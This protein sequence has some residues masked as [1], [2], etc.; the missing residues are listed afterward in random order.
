[1][2]RK[3]AVISTK[4]ETRSCPRRRPANRS[5]GLALGRTGATGLSTLSAAAA[6]GV[7]II[8]FCT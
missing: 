4:A 5:H 6:W 7:S 3:L 2:I 8:P 1:M